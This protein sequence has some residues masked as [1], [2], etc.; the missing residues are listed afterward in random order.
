MNAQ[1]NADN[2]WYYHTM[3]SKGVRM[4]KMRLEKIKEDELSLLADVMKLTPP[5]KDD[6]DD[7]VSAFKKLNIIKP[8]KAAKTTCPPKRRLDENGNI[9]TG[10]EQ[11]RSSCHVKSKSKRVIQKKPLKKQ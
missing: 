3:V 7:L 4:N 11:G 2:M 10:M 1:E 5:T 6:S 9:P 8:V